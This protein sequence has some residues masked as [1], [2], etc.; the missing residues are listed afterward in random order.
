LHQNVVIMHPLFVVIL[1]QNLLLKCNFIKIRNIDQFLLHC[2]LF[3]I[4]LKFFPG[5]DCLEPFREMSACMAQFPGVYGSNDEN[6]MNVEKGDEESSEKTP[7]NTP[8]TE[9]A[10]TETKTGKS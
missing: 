2:T 4:L 3:V 5:S 9:V 10:T 6:V 1:Q 8:S 7:A